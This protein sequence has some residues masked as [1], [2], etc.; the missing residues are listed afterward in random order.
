MVDKALPSTAYLDKEFADYYKKVEHIQANL[1][2]PGKNS[3][4]NH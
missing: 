2:N 3:S 1:S 4:K